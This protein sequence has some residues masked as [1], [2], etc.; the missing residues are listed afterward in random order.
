MKADISRAFSE[1]IQAAEIVAEEN[2]ANEIKVTVSIEFVIKRAVAD[3]EDHDT[4]NATE[5]K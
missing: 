5:S 4:R 2:G 3:V 1:A